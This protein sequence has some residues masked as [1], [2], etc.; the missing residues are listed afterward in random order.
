VKSEL[1]SSSEI[2]TIEKKL[3]EAIHTL[4]IGCETLDIELAFQVFSN[5]PDFLMMGTDGALCDY[6]TYLNNNISYLMTCSNFK[7]TTF[8]EEIRVLNRDMAI[9]AWAYGA[10]A[11]LK[12]GERDIVENA[13]AT[14]VFNKVNDEWKVVHYHE[15]SLP[16]RRETQGH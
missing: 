13:G 2:E 3:R 10:E 9:F 4:S 8:K 16:P 1:L 12:T 7:L 5:S 11:T 14:F 15:S 6:Q